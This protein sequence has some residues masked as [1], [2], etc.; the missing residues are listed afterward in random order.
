[1]DEV[2]KGDKDRSRTA[3]SG[4]RKGEGE[5]CFTAVELDVLK[6][7]DGACSKAADLCERGGGLAGCPETGLSSSNISKASSAETVMSLSL[8]HI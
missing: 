4:A 5:A 3:E 7:D 8:I 2:K 1:M 6:E